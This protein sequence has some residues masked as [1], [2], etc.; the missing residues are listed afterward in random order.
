MKRL[1]EEHEHKLG[2][3]EKKKHKQNLTSLSGFGAG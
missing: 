1:R 3:R 2:E